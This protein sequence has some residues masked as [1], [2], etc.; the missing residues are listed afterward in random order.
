MCRKKEDYINK[1][2]PCVVGKE[3]LAR[4]ERLVRTNKSKNL[5]RNIQASKHQY[6]DSYFIFFRKFLKKCAQADTQ[7]TF[8]ERNL[9]ERSETKERK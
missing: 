5:N 3:S 4:K 7:N 6:Y 8:H 2:T 1:T 9:S